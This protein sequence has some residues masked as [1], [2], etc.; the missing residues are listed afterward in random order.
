VQIT[1]IV[2]NFLMLLAIAHP[3]VYAS[4]LILVRLAG[5]D[6]VNV[7]V[8]V[9]AHQDLLGLDPSFLKKEVENRVSRVLAGGEIVAATSSDHHFFVRIDGLKATPSP[10]TWVATIEISLN[11][12]GL[13]IREFDRK[14]V[15][16][17]TVESWDDSKIVLLHEKSG[18]DELLE[19]LEYM[20]ER[21][22][23]KV[24]SATSYQ[25]SR[26]SALSTD[27]SRLTLA[28]EPTSRDAPRG[29]TL[30]VRYTISNEKDRNESI[31]L[32]PRENV[33][34]GA[35]SVRSFTVGALPCKRIFEIGPWDSRTWSEQ[36]QI[37]A[38]CRD[39]PDASRL[40]AGILERVACTGMIPMT[41]RVPLIHYPDG[42]GQEPREIEL[43]SE[44]VVITISE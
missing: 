31:C 14:E 37:R 17:L 28:I 20:V 26:E 18:L 1:T 8:S 7:S 40:P 13:L 30:T 23:S 34:F 15:D 41:A 9:S 29:G 2:V 10:D 25:Q 42:P 36:I 43:L 5:L 35:H 11:E 4:S 22:V 24:A 39:L 12:E 21:F 19:Q 38:D 32:L 27:S 16:T 6:N 44:P 33:R 3:A